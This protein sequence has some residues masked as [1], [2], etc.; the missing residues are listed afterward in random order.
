M[1]EV[2]CAI[3]MLTDI[4]SLHILSLKKKSG[5]HQY[6]VFVFI[7]ISIPISKISF[8]SHTHIHLDDRGEKLVANVDIWLYK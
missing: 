2:G 7:F 3:C 6:L 4:D 5:R 1:E 8:I